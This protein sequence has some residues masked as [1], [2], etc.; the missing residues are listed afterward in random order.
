MDLNDFKEIND[1]YGTRPVTGRCASRQVLRTTIRPYDIFVRYAG[2][3]FIVVLAGCGADEADLQAGRTAAGGGQPDRSR[4]GR[5]RRLEYR[6]APEP[7]SSRRM[8]TPTMRCSPQLTAACI[9][10]KAHASAATHN[11]R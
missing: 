5:G 7:P 10:T 4:R 11:V 8:A 3:E 2:D 9:S 1:T 6:S